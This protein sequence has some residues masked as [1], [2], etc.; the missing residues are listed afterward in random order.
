M[1]CSLRDS[2]NMKLCQPQV[3][4]KIK[5]SGYSQ[6]GVDSTGLK[7]ELHACWVSHTGSS[8]VLN[9]F[10]YPALMSLASGALGTWAIQKMP[11][12]SR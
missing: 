10:L 7:V 3:N 9:I 11:S 12:I 4:K 5:F 6:T 8:F 2:E 1:T